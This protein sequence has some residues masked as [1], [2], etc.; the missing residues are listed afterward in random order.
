MSKNRHKFKIALF[1]YVYLR[2]ST[3]E[4]ARDA[5][6]LESQ[7]RACQEFCEA[8]GWTILQV[9]QDAG[10]SG[11]DDVERPGF[12]QVM[13]A[14]EKN[15]NVNLVFFDYS[16]FGRHTLRAL[17][18]FERID[19]MGVY[20]VAVTNP[21]IDCRTASGRTARRNEMSKAED[22]SDQHSENQQ[23]RMKVA[24]E[25]GRWCS[26]P[27]L[28][29]QLSR[30]KTKG[31]PNIIPYEP[32]ASLIRK[33]FELVG[34]G[35]DRTVDVRL[36]VTDMGLRSKKGKK[37]NSSTF[38]NMLRNPV[39]IGYMR[40][41]KH[42][43]SKGMHKSLISEQQ[44]RNVQL[45]LKGRKPVTAPYVR[46]RPDFPLRGFLRCAACDTPLTGG[47]SRSHTGR[48]YDY[49]HCPRCRAVKSVPAK[50]AA[51][52][53]TH[54]LTRL[55]VD[56]TFTSDLFVLLQE[57]WNRR[58][59]DG[60]A[61]VENLGKE[62]KEKRNLLEKLMVKYV[63]DD[64]HIRNFFPDMK[65]KLDDEVEAL[66]SKIAQADMAKATFAELLEFTKSMLVDI[67]VAWKRADV[68]QKQRVQN[69]LFPGGLKYDRNNGILNPDNSCLFSQL[70][71]FLGGKMD[72][73]EL[74]GIEPLA[75][76][77]RIQRVD[78][79]GAKPKNTK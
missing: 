26:P 23:V 71:N 25:S 55:R 79:D 9:F 68:D 34:A 6:G 63:N 45:V 65:R 42:G 7:L 43:I 13:Q 24:F 67:S 30:A 77:L 52:E 41:K 58:T 8:R 12:L 38:G 62:L 73:V 50:K 49:Y 4:Q 27:P 33:A 3:E 61:V 31:Q 16:R 57:Q 37:L 69:S 22:F 32:E 78:S 51:E 21:G 40:S 44:F 76:S 53:F 20:S 72:L 36:L 1:V 15:R 11:W 19:G 48:T 28:G 66:E 70:E 35:N 17:N 64:P 54:L 56:Q 2:V 75:S 74:S 18:A 39:Y 5:Y 10:V 47:P 46:N 60:T 29:Y 59:G 14:I